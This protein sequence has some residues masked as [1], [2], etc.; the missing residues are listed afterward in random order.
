MVI[1]LMEANND[2]SNIKWS[3]EVV[4]ETGCSLAFRCFLGEL[5]PG[6]GVVLIK[7][8][9]TTFPALFRQRLYVAVFLGISDNSGVVAFEGIFGCLFSNFIYH[10]ITVIIHFCLVFVYEHYYQFSFWLDEFGTVSID[11]VVVSL[12]I[13]L[14]LC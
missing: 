9:I 12:I 1:M 2:G 6:G 11:L 8:Q 13:N 7:L 10:Y 4:N 14:L 5:M 3:V